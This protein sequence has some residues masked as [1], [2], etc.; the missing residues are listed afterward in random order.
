MNRLPLVLLGVVLVYGCA[1]QAPVTQTD[2]SKTPAGE[3]E[4]ARG[5]SSGELAAPPATQPAPEPKVTPEEVRPPAEST[6]PA[7]K[8][9]P[10]PTPGPASAPSPK[11]TP[12][13]QPAPKPIAEAPAKAPTPSAP[14]PAPVSTPA[15]LSA[16]TTES[17]KQPPDTV[18]AIELDKLPLAVNPNWTLDSGRDPVS[19]RDRCFLR[20]TT[21][22]IED[23][24]GGSNISLIVTADTLRVATRSNIDLSYKD[25]GLQ[26]DSK[27]AFPLQRLFGE[28]DV[29]FEKRVSEIKQQ[30][31][32]GSSVTVTLGFWPTWPVT[33]A[34]G[35][36]FPISGYARA[37]AALATCDRLMP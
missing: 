37:S 33:Q 19:K 20:S 13:A 4:P 9:P 18:P 35:A 30:M 29:L 25:T 11:P 24:Q 14:A 31:L 8:P 23:G 26:V 2:S 3:N 6:Q 15:P 28:T 16:K 10:A 1:A 21:Q 32:G 34:Y 36:R 17:V 7:P 12:A 27:A 22:R 5:T